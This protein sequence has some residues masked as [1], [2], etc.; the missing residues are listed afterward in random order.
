MS[1]KEKI[2]IASKKLFLSEGFRAPTLNLL[3][4]KVGISRGNLTYYFKDK[5][6]L[7][8]ALAEEMWA[9]YEAN[10]G[11][12][13]QFPSWGSTNEVTK[14]YLELQEEYSFIF[15]SKVECFGPGEF[16]S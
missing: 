9:K 1:T 10:I 7:L 4:Q 15:S 13:M 5:E 6:A 12:A 11:R 2:L 16:R 3:A 8:E 14:V